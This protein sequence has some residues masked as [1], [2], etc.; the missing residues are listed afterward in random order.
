LKTES[1]IPIFNAL[2]L[3][4]NSKLKTQTK[5]NIMEKGSWKAMLLSTSL[6]FAA[7]LLANVATPHVTKLL[8]KKD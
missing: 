5:K 4:C 1:A 6:I 7:V 3:H 2:K 8:E